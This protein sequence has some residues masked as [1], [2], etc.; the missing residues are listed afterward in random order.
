M[1]RVI[2]HA[3]AFLDWFGADPAAR[4][5]RAEYEQGLVAVVVPRIFALQVLESAARRSG[6][7]SGRLQQLA[8][9]LERVGFEQRDP[10][11]VDLAAW[12]ARGLSGPD[13]A[14]AA[15]ASALDLP[16]V[17][18]DP[19]LLGTVAVATPAGRL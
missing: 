7:A 2:L 9:A 8:G 15:L 13:A 6:W 12:L 18:N 5:L 11:P 17:T 10:P 4:A 3:P 16:L 14:Y 19:Q 1:R